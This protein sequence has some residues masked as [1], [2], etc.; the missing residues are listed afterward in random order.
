[1]PEKRAQVKNEQQYEAAGRK[2]GKAT[3]KKR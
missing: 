2:G 3:A 1:M